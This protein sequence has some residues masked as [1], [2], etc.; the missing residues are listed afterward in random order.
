M[1]GIAAVLVFVPTTMFPTPSPSV[2][3]G[4]LVM[5]E[6][7]ADL[8]R[9]RLEDNSYQGEGEVLRLKASLAQLPASGPVK[10]RVELY[11]HLGVAK[12]FLGRE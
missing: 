6:L 4:Q 8:S 9:M 1:A 2:D 12:L 5:V 3:G 11:N 10:T 7:L